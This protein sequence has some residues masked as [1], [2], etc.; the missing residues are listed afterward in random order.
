MTEIE[1][2]QQVKTK[3]QKES[4]IDETRIA[5]KRT[6]KNY[7][8]DCRVCTMWVYE[9]FSTGGSPWEVF[10]RKVALK[11]CSKLTREQ[12]AKVWFQQT[13]FATLL[14]SHFVMCVLL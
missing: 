5:C 9:D 7:E 13:C 4:N 1:T 12:H 2:K 11:I 6:S 10:L 8:T 3:K 14:K